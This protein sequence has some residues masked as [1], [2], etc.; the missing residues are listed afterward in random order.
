MTP[1]GTLCPSLAPARAQTALRLRPCKLAGA[2]RCC[3]RASAAV[4]G[5]HGWGVSFQ[6]D[7]HVSTSQKWPCGGS[8]RAAWPGTPGQSLYFRVEKHFGFLDPWD[9]DSSCLPRSKMAINRTYHRWPLASYPHRLMLFLQ[10]SRKDS[11]IS[12]L[13]LPFCIACAEV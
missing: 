1:G 12:N 13:A 11:R 5:S 7:Q 2:D 3:G 6:W 8:H 10:G 9:P 4:W